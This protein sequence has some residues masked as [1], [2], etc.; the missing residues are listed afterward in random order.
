MFDSAKMEVALFLHRGGRPNHL[1][2]KPSAK[3]RVGEG[4]ISFNK[5]ATTWLGIWMDAHLTFKEQHN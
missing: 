2:P 5:R 4:V 1:R 3:I